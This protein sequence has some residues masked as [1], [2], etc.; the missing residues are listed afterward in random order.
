MVF[1]LQLFVLFV[2][3][4]EAKLKAARM[5]IYVRRGGPNYQKGLA[6][7]RSLGDEIGVPIEVYTYVPHNKSTQYISIYSILTVL[8]LCLISRCMVLKQQ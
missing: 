5:H 2:N 3:E 1:K 7:M 4:Q 8:S 6:K